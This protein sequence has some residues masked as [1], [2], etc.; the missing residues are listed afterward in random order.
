MET[1]YRVVEFFCSGVV[2][3]NCVVVIVF[4]FLLLHVAIIHII[5][6]NNF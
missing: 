4:C 2:I 5:I 1:E 3:T 6:I